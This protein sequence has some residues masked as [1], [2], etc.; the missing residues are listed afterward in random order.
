METYSF[1]TTWKVKAGISEVWEVIMNTEEWPSWWKGVRNV[2]V[3]QH[4]D[5]NGNGTITWY[6]VGAFFHSLQF[7]LKTISV[8]K[9]RFA[10]GIAA[11]DLL[12]TGRWEFSE[13]N[14]ITVLIYYWKVKTTKKWMNRWAWLL[15]PLFVFSHRMVMRW[16]EKG[17]ARWLRAKAL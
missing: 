11:G 3:L 1:A 2:K 4:G 7:T 16:G 14:G 9:H 13:S 10:E 12:G 17:L 15:R 5:A 6:E 8:E